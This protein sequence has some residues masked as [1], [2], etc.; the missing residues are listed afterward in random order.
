V[1]GLDPNGDLH[2]V[3]FIGAGRPSSFLFPPDASLPTVQSVLQFA[4]SARR[5]GVQLLW[6]WP[7]FAHPV[8]VTPPPPFLTELLRGAGFDV[9][10]SPEDETFPLDWFMDSPYHANPCCRRVRTEELIRRLRPALGLP[11]APEKI[12]GVFLL[13]G[14]DHR[15]TDGNLFADDP[16][17]VFRYL[18]SDS[19]PR[20]ISPAEVARLIR[21]GTRVFTDAES[22][23]PLLASAGLKLSLQSR[24]VMSVSQWFGRYPSSL[25]CVAASPGRKIDPGWKTAVPASLYGRRANGEAAAAIFGSG[26]YAGVNLI[27]PVAVQQSLEKLAPGAFPCVVSLRTDA[28]IAVDFRQFVSS[29]GGMCAVVIDPE[30]GTVIDKAV[31]DPG[32]EI[33][34]WRLYR[35]VADPA[36]GRRAL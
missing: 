5:K 26:R 30:M 1:A 12:S 27:S 10:D 4:S 7:S 35:V 8:T 6:S 21:G 18:G 25:F 17:M 9:L 32:A 3:P 28:D 14:I 23:R 36:S 24:E 29:P 20:A 34:T 2:I 15:L 19:D 31:F 22:A 11:S 16:G 33:E 13:A